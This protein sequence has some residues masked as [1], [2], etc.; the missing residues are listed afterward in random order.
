M[1]TVADWRENKPTILALHFFSS[2]TPTPATSF[3]SFNLIL[4]IIPNRFASLLQRHYN[5]ALGPSRSQRRLR[6]MA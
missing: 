6:I 3:D 1:G 4:K 2:F 5:I